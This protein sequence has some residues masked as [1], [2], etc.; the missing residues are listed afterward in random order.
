MG[1]GGAKVLR[2]VQEEMEETNRCVAVMVFGT[3]DKPDVMVL[4]NSTKAV[5]TR[6]RGGQIPDNRCCEAQRRQLRSFEE[7]VLLL[8][9]A[10]EVRY[11]SKSMTTSSTGSTIVQ[12]VWPPYQ[13]SVLSL[14]VDL[15]SSGRNLWE[16]C[17][18][19]RTALARYR[20]TTLTQKQETGLSKVAVPGDERGRVLQI[21]SLQHRNADYFNHS[22]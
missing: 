15:S 18:S 17:R 9:Y 8:L 14:S 22:L 5:I 11:P 1:P 10:T 6:G 3:C 7:S 19:G 20:E 4:G 12:A 13:K 2:K 21:V 16:G